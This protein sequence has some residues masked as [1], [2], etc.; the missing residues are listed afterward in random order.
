MERFEPGL[1]VMSPVR[2]KQSA[3]C[4]GRQVGWLEIEVVLLARMS[5]G[6]ISKAPEANSTGSATADSSFL[7]EDP[8]LS[9]VPK[10]FPPV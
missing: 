1:P 9:I 7:S 10:T 2:A 5:L 4:R 8:V 6:C 3:T